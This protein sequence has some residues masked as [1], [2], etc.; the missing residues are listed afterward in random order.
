MSHDYFP[1][2]VAT[3]AMLPWTVAGAQTS[4]SGSAPVYTDKGELTPPPHYREWIYLSTGMNMSYIKRFKGMSHDMF[5]NVFVN[6]EAYH[7]FLRTGTWPDKT[8]LVLEVR[9]ATNKGSINKQGYYQNGEIMGLEVHVKDAA[10]FQGGWA[11][12]G[13]N[14]GKPAPQIAH[15]AD[16]YACH[17]DHAAVDTTFVQFYPTLLEVA[18]KK[19]TLSATYAP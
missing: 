2:L 16:C 15:T 4:A 13:D 3:L 17:K 10:R 12:F 5:S 9:G 8:M 6:P 14:D 18:R 11:F 7:E 1:V 19:G